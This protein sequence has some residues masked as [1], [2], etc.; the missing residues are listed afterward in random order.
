MERHWRMLLRCSAGSLSAVPGL[1]LRGLPVRA[2]VTKFVVCLL[3]VMAVAGINANGRHRSVDF[4]HMLRT[5]PDSTH[6]VRA[7]YHTPGSLLVVPRSS[8]SVLY[9]V[10]S[11]SIVCLS[12]SVACDRLSCLSISM[13]ARAKRFHW[14]QSH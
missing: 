6:R 2:S 13:L 3:Q 11:W 12:V 9:T 4:P 8:Q 14:Y 1:R 7:S 5:P 10:I